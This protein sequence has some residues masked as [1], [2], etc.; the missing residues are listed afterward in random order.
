[1]TSCNKTFPDS[2]DVSN[3]A[4]LLGHTYQFHKPIY[5]Y[6]TNSYESWCEEEKVNTFLNKTT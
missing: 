4:T 6:I 5:E 3:I 2:L 1:M